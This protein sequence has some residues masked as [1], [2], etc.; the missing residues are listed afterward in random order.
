MSRRRSSNPTK[1]ISITLPASQIAQLDKVL[2]YEQSRSAWI[3]KAISKRLDET[4]EIEECLDKASV[5]DLVSALHFVGA[6]N[7]KMRYHI[8]DAWNVKI[9]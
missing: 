9:S 8:L 4:K 5:E 3:S 2:A 7:H 6:I 1:A